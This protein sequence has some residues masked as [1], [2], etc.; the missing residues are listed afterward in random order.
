[1]SYATVSD[2]LSFSRD[3][4]GWQSNSPTFS[5]TYVRRNR[6]SVATPAAMAMSSLPLRGL[7]KKGLVLSQ[8]CDIC[9][10]HETQYFDGG[11]YKQNAC[12]NNPASLY[13]C[14]QVS[15]RIAF[16]HLIFSTR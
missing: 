10:R 6:I 8:P 11:K 5:T 12:L 7:D 16:T 13:E 9:E 15:G 4:S 14:I 2:N 1:M 3:S